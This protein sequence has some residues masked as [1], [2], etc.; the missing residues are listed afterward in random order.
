M[1]P[2]TT[3]AQAAP[4]S[5]I[6]S[7][8]LGRLPL[9]VQL[10]IAMI[11]LAVIPLIIVTVLAVSIA[12]NALRGQSEQNTRSNVQ[13]L[14]SLLENATA[15][16]AQNVAIVANSADAGVF[17][18]PANARQPFLTSLNSIWGFTDL[19]VFDSAGNWVAGTRGSAPARPAG[20][21][22]WFQNALKLPAGQVYFGAIE[23]ASTGGQAQFNVAAPVYNA[24]RQVIG[25]VR[26]DWNPTPLL[27]SLRAAYPN[28]RID[29]LTGSGDRF[30]STVAGLGVIAE[31]ERLPVRLTQA[32][33]E[34]LVVYNNGGRDVLA[35]FG[36]V[37]AP[38]N[39]QGLNWIVVVESDMAT[40]LQ[41]VTQLTVLVGLIVF[42]AL[43]SIVLVALGMSRHLTRPVFELAQL[44][45][46]VR[47]ERDAL[48]SQISKLLDEVSTV[49]EGDLTVQ[50]EVTADTLGSVADAFNYM[51]EELRG[52]IQNVNRTTLQVA[53]S[54][55]QI[56]ENS[57]EL[58]KQTQYQ[59]NRILQVTASVDEVATVA[60]SVARNAAVGAEIAST[61]RANAGEGAE[62]V[63]QT[64]EGMQRIRAEVQ[65]TSK[66]I[67]RLGESSQEIGQ[68]VQLIE[69]IS[70]QT[71]L[72]ALN[73]AIQAAMAGE[74]GRGFAVVADEVRRLAERA[75]Q[76]TK[77]IN[78]LVNSIQGDTNEAVLAM[79]SSTREVVEGSRL[80]DTAGQ[81]LERINEVV[82]QLSELIAEIANAAERQA[83]A[84]AE[85]KS[86]MAEITET[87]R[88]ATSSTREAAESVEYLARL[89]EQLR[90]SVAAFRLEATA[91]APAT[92]SSGPPAQ[93]Q[94]QPQPRSTVASAA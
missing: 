73:A 14:S 87:T 56:L 63:R 40:L 76:A 51:V 13:A 66:K 22:D 21:T 55:R 28:E 60:Q 78:A 65:E 36:R 27:R 92:E 30:M 23:V 37:N 26:A 52:I 64:V 4:G 16:V 53:T 69:D 34:G 75:G 1:A 5:A 45:E 32:Q 9:Q 93:P 71:N 81:R 8:S 3:G 90:A 25:V 48:Q 62:A 19:S 79:E 11:A 86:A 29:L 35:G 49:A 38:V 41:P 18:A 59:A 24:Q 82:Q 67:K 39:V 58:A 42:V 94:P 83:L 15:T 70:D 44:S 17:Q 12:S 80:A 6:S 2:L 46:R 7:S 10:G 68:I 89:A 72:L 43:I 91:E 84:S 50:A 61:A 54:T 77:Q 33:G 31:A 85:V 88:L 57:G 47:A 20:E 74:H